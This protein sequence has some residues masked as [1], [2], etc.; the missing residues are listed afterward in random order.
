MG[1]LQ[2]GGSVSAIFSH[3]R[4]RLPPIIYT[5]IDRRMNS[6]QLCRWRFSHKE[7]S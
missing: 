2:E 4:G 7:T 5:L 1:I 6:L 3:T